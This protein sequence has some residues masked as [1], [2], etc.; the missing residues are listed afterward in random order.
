METKIHTNIVSNK[1]RSIQTKIHIAISIQKQLNKRPKTQTNKQTN[2]PQLSKR[3]T[4]HCFLRVRCRKVCARP[5]SC[6]DNG[7][8]R[9]PE[10]RALAVSSSSSPSLPYCT[11]SSGSP[12]P[13]TGTFE[14]HSASDEGLDSTGES[15]DKFPP[16]AWP[17]PGA[18][19]SFP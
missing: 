8:S 5:V 3:P 13:L 16:G 6:W 15:R 10:E 17:L 11:M 18:A 2:A 14:S 12:R 4:R 19:L 1:Y 9:R 7:A